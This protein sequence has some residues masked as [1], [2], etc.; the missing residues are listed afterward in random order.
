MANENSL[1]AVV[2]D[3]K[4]QPSTASQIS[5]SEKQR[6]SGTQLDKNA[7]LKLLVAQ[8]K[9]QDPLEPTDNTEYISQLATFSQLEEMQNMTS[10]M[11]LQRASG[12]VG[13]EVVIKTI[14]AS[15][16]NT[17]YKQGFVDYVVYENGKAY[18]SIDDSLYSI[19][20][21]YEVMDPEYSLAYNKAKNFAI[22]FANLPKVEYLTL[23]YEKAVKDLRDSYNSMNDYEKTFISKEVLDEL[24]RY[25]AKIKELNLGKK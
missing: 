16:G 21:V 25:E 6:S 7:F 23:D 2:K 17:E 14:N 24:D 15:T 19:D 22:N 12:L 11:S 18:V 5:L 13:E 4:I 20:D 3:G 1:T 9:F 10:G 8:M